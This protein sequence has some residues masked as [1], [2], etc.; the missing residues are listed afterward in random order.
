MSNYVNKLFLSST[1][2]YFGHFVFIWLCGYPSRWCNL[3]L[4]GRFCLLILMTSTR[5]HNLLND[6]ADADDALCRYQIKVFVV[7]PFLG[8]FSGL[9]SFSGVDAYND[10]ARRQEMHSSYLRFWR[11]SFLGSYLI[12]WCGCIYNDVTSR[13]EGAASVCILPTPPGGQSWNF[14]RARRSPW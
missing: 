11:N 9:S 13:Q 5:G 14:L 2:S 7:R 10:N 1:L 6:D 8:N 12:L 4:M 3:H